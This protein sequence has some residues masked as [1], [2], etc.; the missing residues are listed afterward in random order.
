V[1]VWAAGTALDAHDVRRSFHRMVEK[2]GLDAKT[3]TPRELRHSS[4]SLLSDSG[5]P[6]EHLATRRA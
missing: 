1:F 6:L 2:A 5:V 4:V 3:C